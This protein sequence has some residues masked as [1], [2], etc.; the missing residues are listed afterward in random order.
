MP[1]LF[2]LP[3]QCFSFHFNDD[4]YAFPHWPQDFRPSPIHR[5]ATSTGVTGL[6][7]TAKQ[8]MEYEGAERL[9]FIER[10]PQLAER[11]IAYADP[12]R[13]QHPALPNTLTVAEGNRPGPSPADLHSNVL[14]IHAYGL[15]FKEGDESMLAGSKQA[16]VQCIADEINIPLRLMLKVCFLHLLTP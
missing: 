5:A 6:T 9:R 16:V 3:Q 7:R 4:I 10:S 15:M 14:A 8:V 13:S 2:G 12:T 1:T 11:L